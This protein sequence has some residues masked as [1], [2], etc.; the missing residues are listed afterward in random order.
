MMLKIYQEAEAL[1]NIP[2]EP[3]HK[4]FKYY[5]FPLSIFTISENRDYTKYSA[6][7]KNRGGRSYYIPFGWMRFGLQVP[8]TIFNKDSCV[9]FYTADIQI[10]KEICISGK[11]P[12][13]SLPGY[14]DLSFVYVTP[15]IDHLEFSGRACE[16]PR[17][18]GLDLGGNRRYRVVLQCRIPSHLIVE[19]PDPSPYYSQ[20]IRENAIWRV[21]A[22]SLVAYAICIKELE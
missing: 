20:S 22:G 16:L 10:L 21:P 7:I 12:L 15:F 19:V 1:R 8:K 18:F 3:P 5:N 9:G 11:F 14:S 17:D 2:K 4:L 6:V 13:E